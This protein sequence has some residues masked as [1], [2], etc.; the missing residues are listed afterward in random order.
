MP[1]PCYVLFKAY[2]KL[3]QKQYILS[4][5]PYFFKTKN[6]SLASGNFGKCFIY[7]IS[8]ITINKEIISKISYMKHSMLK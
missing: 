6:K 7:I 4:E 1:H 8:I 3:P 2:S 5:P